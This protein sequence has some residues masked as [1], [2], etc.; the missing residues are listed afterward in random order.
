METTLDLGVLRVGVTVDASLAAT[1]QSAI[2]AMGFAECSNPADGPVVRLRHVQQLPA[3]PPH[4][5]L[6]LQAHTHARGYRVTD[7]V[8]LWTPAGRSLVRAGGAEVYLMPGAALSEASWHLVASLQLLARQ[9]GAYAL[10]AAGLDGSNGGL[11]V[12]GPSDVGKSTLAMA[13]VGQGWGFVSD[14]AVLL[15]D[16]GEVEALPFRRRFGLDDDALPPESARHA[17]PQPAEERKWSVDVAATHAAQARDRI[18]PR[19]LVFPEIVDA[20]ESTAEPLGSVDAYASLLAQ[21]GTRRLIDAHTVAHHA[22]LGRLLAQAPAVRLRA[23]RDVLHA[24]ARVAY[25]L[26]HAFPPAHE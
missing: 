20:D 8:F 7:G 21:V 13:L 18:V 5:R 4:A 1:I 6:Q 11:L 22:L 19:R 24:P 15:R 26:S 10:H 3:T 16:A 17:V 23:G 9:V 25:L 14:D 12:V 2:R